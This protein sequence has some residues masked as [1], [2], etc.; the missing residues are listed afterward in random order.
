MVILGPSGVVVFDD[1]K[2]I[3]TTNTIGNIVQ[4]ETVVNEYEN[5]KYYE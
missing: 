3:H 1:R 2:Q 4:K 5:E